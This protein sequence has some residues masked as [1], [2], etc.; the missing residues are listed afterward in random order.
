MKP[1]VIESGPEIT[2]GDPDQAILQE[3][4]QLLTNVKLSPRD[5]IRLEGETVV[6]MVIPERI[7][8]GQFESEVSLYAFSRAHVNWPRL[9]V[10]AQPSLAQALPLRRPF[11]KSG[12]CVLGPLMA[13]AQYQLSAR[14]PTASERVEDL[15]AAVS[16]A[17]FDPQGQKISR[18]NDAVV[19]VHGKVLD[20]NVLFDIHARSGD[21]QPQFSWESIGVILDNPATG[22]T[23][24]PKWF[25]NGG[26]LEFH[27]K[28]RNANELRLLTSLPLL[29]V[30]VGE[31]GHLFALA[32]GREQQS[33]DKP[34]IF[35]L[36][37]ASADGRVTAVARR[38]PGGAISLQVE[39]RDPALRNAMV[40]LQFLTK[41]GDVSKPITLVLELDKRDASRN[42]I[43]WGAWIGEVSLPEDAMMRVDVFPRG[44]GAGN[45]S[46]E[47]R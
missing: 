31:A 38:H 45:P 35:E 37:A 43:Y 26:N 18:V 1:L 4:M 42:L 36:H 20:D 24:P 11:T 6:V 2:R 39:T 30:L 16:Q 33:P 9:H 17:R 40:S 22:E 44:L 5:S 28:T 46:M 25:G 3:V 8:H 29:A 15:L 21:P 47:S 41:H 23:Y 19:T 34:E 13:D 12:A 14:F 27:V 32:A 10:V 7:D